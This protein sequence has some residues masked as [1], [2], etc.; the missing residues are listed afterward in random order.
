MAH[1]T[2]ARSIRLFRAFLREQS[3]PDHFYA[4]P[5]ADSAQQLSGYVDL[6]R[7]RVLDVGGGPGYFADAFRAAGASYLGIDPDVGELSARGDPAA[8]MIRASGTA[9]PIRTGAVDVRV[10]GAFTALRQLEPEKLEAVIDLL[11][12]GPGEKIYRLA[13]EDINVPPEIDS[14]R[15]CPHCPARS[16]PARRSWT[17]RSIPASRASSDRRPRSPG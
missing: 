17:S 8:G 14:S 3:D 15:S 16:L 13:P 11:S 6:R 12:S 1:A 2:L 9:L 7:K 10:R 4:I 5:A